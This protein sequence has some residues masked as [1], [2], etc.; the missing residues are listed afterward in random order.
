M[1]YYL[2]DG[3]KQAEPEF[4]FAGAVPGDTMNSYMMAKGYRIGAEYT[5]SPELA[6]VYMDDEFGG[7]I[8]TDFLANTDSI[9]PVS[10][11]MKEVI[12]AIATNEIEYLQFSLFDLKERL[13]S[14]DYFVVNIIGSIDCMDLE[15]SKITWSK[16]SPGEIVDIDQF[17]LSADK[18]EEVPDLFRIKED[19]GEYVVSERLK[20]EFEK[21]EFTNVNLIELE[22][23]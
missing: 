19:P 20:A 8:A 2:V 9:L 10:K 4:C 13:V 14:D 5:D 7:F 3:L 22:V 18:L 17:V 12:E 6:T 1:K 23:V 21:H 16:S 11:R 15:A